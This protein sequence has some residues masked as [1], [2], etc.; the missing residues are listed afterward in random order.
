MIHWTWLLLP[1][2]IAVAF[3]ILLLS[4]TRVA[5]YE[6]WVAGWLQ[7]MK[8]MNDNVAVN[9]QGKDEVPEVDSLPRVK[10]QG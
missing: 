5:Y 1:S 7:C 8:S 4:V 3:F 10:K 6:G 2:G 9:S